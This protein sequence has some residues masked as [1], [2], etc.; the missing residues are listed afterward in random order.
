MSNARPSSITRWSST[1]STRIL[2]DPVTLLLLCLPWFVRSGGR[3]HH[4]FDE[5]AVPGP[6]VNHHAAANLLST[7]SHAA[8]PVVPVA[9][10]HLVRV[11]AGAVIADAQLQ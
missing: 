2:S 3:R 7:L 4:G 5:R 9:I 10:G 11:E 1:H 6:R 8:Q